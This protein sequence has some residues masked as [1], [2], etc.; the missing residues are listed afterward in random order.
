[1]QTRPSSH[2]AVPAEVAT[3]YVADR[4]SPM[5]TPNSTQEVTI[6]PIEAVIGPL[7]VDAQVEEADTKKIFQF[8]HL[9]IYNG[10]M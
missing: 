7:T 2:R 5:N 10:M 9:T 8:F 3:A 4:T 1:M 6:A